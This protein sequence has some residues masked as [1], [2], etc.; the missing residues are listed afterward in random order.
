[1]S[2][3]VHGVKVRGLTRKEVKGLKEFGFYLSFYSPPI[4][5]PARVDEGV[6]KV[7]GLCV[8][9]PAAFELLEDQDHNKTTQVFSAICRETYGARDEEK[10]LPKSGNGSQTDNE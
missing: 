3:E 8:L 2:R 10:N 9:D 4:E 7:L 5:D 6:E 1:M